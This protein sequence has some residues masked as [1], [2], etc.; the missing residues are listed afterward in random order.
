MYRLDVDG[1]PVEEPDTL[2]WGRWFGTADRSLA[3]DRVGAVEVSTVFLG[4]D[5]NY[6]GGPPL[7]WETMT[8]AVD[9]TSELHNLQDRYTTRESALA[10][11]KAMVARVRG[12]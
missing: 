11:H 9:E 1:N 12:L 6:S 5:H 4:L 7:L 10:G 2:A 8:F 3:Y